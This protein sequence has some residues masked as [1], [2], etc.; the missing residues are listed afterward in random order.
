VAEQARSN[1]ASITFYDKALL[2]TEH[3]DIY[4]QA[5][6]DFYHPETPAL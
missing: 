1:V 5:L 4:L 2:D 6:G 3:K